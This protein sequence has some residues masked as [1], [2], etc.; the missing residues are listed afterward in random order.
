MPENYPSTT[1]R[2]LAVSITGASG[3][4]YA[5][6]FLRE[7]VRIWDR[8]WLT[9]SDNALAVAQHELGLRGFDPARDLGLG[10]YASRVSLMGASDMSVPPS[11]GSYR[12][13]GLV[14]VP[15]SMGTLGRVASGVS[16]DLTARIADV[17]LKE[18]RGLVLVT[19]ET[20]LSAI[21]LRNMLA[22]QEAGAVVMPA[23]PGFYHRPRTV[24]DL[25][26]FVVARMLQALGVEQHL[27]KGW[28]EE[29]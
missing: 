12:C 23:A 14:I 29:E 1:E 21:H 28:G 15:C 27:V 20:P 6:R 16:T 22:L 7:A 13:D 2:R 3:A 17:C 9:F 11:S 24:D 8:I 5:V 4:I 25:V 26:S 18:R 19:R 10:D